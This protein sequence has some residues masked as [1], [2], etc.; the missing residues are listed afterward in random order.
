MGGW[1]ASP[2]AFRLG[3]VEVPVLEVGDPTRPPIVLLPGLTDGL[4][5][6][7][8]PRTRAILEAA[9]LPMDR[10]HGFVLSHRMPALP[11]LTTRVLASDAAAVLDRVLDRPAVVVG[12]S[13][14][15]MVAQHLAADHPELVASLVLSA[16][17]ARADDGLRALLAHWDALLRDRRF[18]EFARD[19]VETSF[20]GEELTRRRALLAARI[21]DEPSDELVAR[22]RA[23]SAACAGHDALDRLPAVLAPTLVLAGSV[24]VIA[25]LAHGQQLAESLPMAELEV[26]HGLGHGFPEQAAD[27]FVDRVAR[28]LETV[29]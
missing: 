6:I 17:T 5:P 13:L 1:S 28:F 25:P 9:P 14:G 12:H 2:R 10:F 19:A 4:A 3:G 7:T 27:R 26:F 11:P 24:D 29:A 23:L 8:D 15:A 16:T 20:T 22:H 21:A 18:A